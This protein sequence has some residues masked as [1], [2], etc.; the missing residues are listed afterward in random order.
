MCDVLLPALAAVAVLGLLNSGNAGG[1]CIEIPQQ[2]GNVT[3]SNY[4]VAQTHHQQHSAPE[5]AY[6][7][8]QAHYQQQHHQPQYAG[9]AYAPAHHQQPYYG[10]PQANP[11]GGHYGYSDQGGVGAGI[12]Y[13]GQQMLGAG[14]QSGDDGVGFGANVGGVGAGVDFGPRSY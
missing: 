3:H 7:A 9:P 5:F 6:A 14:V 10:A 2:V 8:P 11:Y 12:N 1:H 13:D 4:Y